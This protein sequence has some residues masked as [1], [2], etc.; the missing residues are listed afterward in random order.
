MQRT[1]INQYKI[2]Q[3]IRAG[4]PQK[5]VTEIRPRLSLPTRF[6]FLLRFSFQVSLDAPRVEVCDT[7]PCGE[8]VVDDMQRLVIE[9]TIPNLQL[10]GTTRGHLQN[11]NYQT[12]A[13]TLPLTFKLTLLCLRMWRFYGPLQP[14][15]F[16]KTRAEM[17][18]FGQHIFST[19]FIFDFVP[20]IL[21]GVHYCI[22]S[23]LLLTA[24]FQ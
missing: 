7:D 24:N 21:L 3:N 10:R 5:N 12:I 1:G 23:I 19:Y 17:H 8:V 9:V 20:L 4:S 15:Y 14:C 2:Q 6:N 13:S 11:V 18:C 22:Y 16:H